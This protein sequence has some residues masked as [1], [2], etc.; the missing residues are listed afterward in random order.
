M[1]EIS[2][3]FC[4]SARLPGAHSSASANVQGQAVP[5]RVPVPAPQV[6]NLE[7]IL[8]ERDACGVRTC[9]SALAFVAASP[10]L[11]YA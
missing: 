5:E 3:G 10:P 11:Y 9:A 4:Q 6:A 1:Q 8:K 7:D 2:H